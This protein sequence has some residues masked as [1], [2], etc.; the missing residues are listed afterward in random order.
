[1]NPGDS[2]RKAGEVLG[3]PVI[4][5]GAWMRVES[6]YRSAELAPQP[7]LSRWQ[8]HPEAMLRDLAE[9]LR[10]NRWKPERWQQVP[11]PK[12]GALLRHYVMPTVRDQ[13]AF[14][15]HMV[16]LGPIL[17]SQ[18]ANFAYGNRWY[19][20]IA[21]DRRVE[22][23]RWVHRPYPVL[24]NRIFLSYARSHGLFRRVAHWTVAR[25]T[26]ATLPAEDDA[27][28]VQRP[29]DYEDGALPKWTRE[30]WW[31]GAVGTPRAFWASLDIELA[32][33]S[34]RIH[35][36]ATAMERSLRQPIDLHT[37]FE[38]EAGDIPDISMDDV[39]QLVNF[40]RLFD[41]CP[42]PVSEA[43]AVED[44]RVEIGRRLT[45]ALGEVTLNS[46]GIPPDAWRPPRNHPLPKVAVEPYD[47]IPTGL[48]ISG[49]LLNVALQEP[50]RAIGRYL[51]ETSAE[52]RGAIVRFAD[53][54]YVL[55]RSAGG[56][57]SLVEAVH[58]ALSGVGATSLATPNEVSNVC[59]NFK[60]IKPDAA[61]TVI[62]EF[63]LENGWSECD[64][65]GQPLPPPRQEH[66]SA[67]VT[68]WWA[69]KASSDEF[70]PHREALERAAIEQGDVGP[71]VTSLVELL[72]DMGTDTLR[73]RFG[74]GARNHLARLHELA[75]FDIED[76][77]VRPDTRR[78][79]SVNRLVRAWL[80]TARET[81]EQQRKLRQIRGTIG[82]VLDRTPWKF[83][84]WRA[85]VRGAARR[86]LDNSQDKRSIDEEASEWLANQ[87]RRIAFVGD[88][89]DSAAWMNAWP[90]IDADDG[91]AAE[92]PGRW[93]ELYLSFLRA[94]F[95]RALAQVLRDLERHGA[96]VAHE[97]ADA[98]VPLPSLWTT[99]AVG[100]GDH[101][102]VAVSLGR[103]DVWVDALYAAGNAKELAAWP[104]ELDE[105]VGAILAAHS[106][107]E[108]A[109]AWRSTAGPGP[110]LQ[111]PATVRLEEMPKASELLSRLGRLRR[112]GPRRNRKL[113]NWALANVRLGHWNDGLGGVLF[114]ASGQPRI[115][116][117]WDDS[118]GALAAGIALG[119]FAWIKS[120]LA[121]RAIPSMR[122]DDDSLEID[123]FLLRDYARARGVIVGQ[124]A[125]QSSPPT[126]H[127]LLW[128]TPM[129]AGLNEWPMAGWETPAVGLPSRVAAALL[130]SVRR[131]ST[132][133]GWAPY[134]GP[135]TWTIEDVDG[136][137]ATGRRGQFVP[138]EEPEPTEQPISTD[139]SMEWE[140][141]PHAAFYRPFASASTHEVHADS[142]VLYCDVLL[143][144]TV[145]D[146][147]ER[148]LDVLA[149]WGA[150]GTPFVDR[151]S[152]R[153]RIHFPPE[154]WES[155]EKVLRWSESPRL[156]VTSSGA[157]LVES[158]AGW[159]DE[160]V[161]WEDF[162]PER[163]DVSLSLS[164]DLEIVRTIRPASDLRGPDLPP[165]LRIEDTSIVDELVAR[166]GQVD[167]WP[168]ETEVVKRFPAI[169]SATAN[170]MIEQVSNVFLAPA[171]GVG[172][173]GPRLVVL[174]ELAI[175]QQEV[176]SLRDLVRSE[177]KAAVAGLYWRALTPPF[178][179]PKGFTP[180]WAC[181]VNEAEL[182][183]PVG[184]GRGPPSVRW[185][186]VRKPVPAHIEDGLGKSLSKK[187][188][189]TQWRMLRGKRWYR[190]VHPEW[191]DFTVAIC[192]DLIDAAPWRALR[193]E[194]LHLLMV[195][196]N[197]DVD[198][199][200]SLTW[201]RAYE[202]YVNVASVNHGLF[203]GSFLWTPRRTHGRELARLRGG[204][205]V[206][207]ADVR[208]PVKG[209]LS[210]QRIG[211][212]TAVDQSA[213]H[214]QGRK[215]TDT[216]YKAPPPG[217]RRRS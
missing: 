32:Y 111:V 82:F 201:I 20:P 206:L 210:A 27:G 161:S 37:L 193:G 214:W 38:A 132:P 180:K 50:D 126:V 57:L 22:P 106:T 117:T 90:E 31:Q 151:W 76:E 6:W 46:G 61:Q 102:R 100:E 187:P 156:S 16:A 159:S 139:R 105:F 72:S 155:I 75:R 192:A 110:E 145:L 78:A 162:L 80:P 58:G 104:W 113:D 35:Q 213:D 211:V 176:G 84:I 183:V 177:G 21:W 147:A 48:A 86:P 94:A 92:R 10:N 71:F 169:S 17:D 136:V 212:A 77:Q 165:E 99:R 160:V 29:E 205:L 148:I 67:R 158:L 30:A 130:K 62:G 65:C 125:T 114:P 204:N 195:A 198:L 115:S 167:A 121:L 53:D 144:L 154:A 203:G 118:R 1:M 11:Y 23:A 13:V 131:N 4:L 137:L 112:T 3:N 129:D 189:A 191:G 190:F 128:G 175:P 174:P 74:E 25:M 164:P 18:V 152:W 83:A 5:H 79:Y 178:R 34:V 149:R 173:A 9:A 85:V 168:T 202:N 40:H 51:E 140:V 184:D 68:D 120:A 197:K 217:F 28:P 108:L 91:H 54:M 66:T 194:L 56:L 143:L 142:Y 81:G 7:E 8:L 196:F 188:S 141:V 26:N 181:F 73:Q 45:R 41:G 98:W 207:I 93:R 122:G 133:S 36:L 127:R 208:L 24:T 179:P 153:S 44:V 96:R 103:I 52:C 42:R 89:R 95:W 33:P 157:R 119:C 134:R 47:G 49:V 146:G 88:Q 87:L 69:A 124:G 70:V 135:L 19:R 216:E 59:I 170:A 60:K 12:K 64:I 39:S 138:D 150:S 63:L 215:T 200:D 182:I 166:V 163:I 43:L 171:Q 116:R 55:S 97:E 172:N 15:A 107:V 123:A 2:A 109:Q 209:L 199:F 14:M 101:A 185:F 186:R